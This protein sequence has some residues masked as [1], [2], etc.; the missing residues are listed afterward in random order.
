MKTMQGWHNSQ[1]QLT[2]YLE[3]GDEVEEAFA[4][5]ALNIMPPAFWS[6]RIIQIG[7]PH[8]HVEGIPTFA[9]FYRDAGTWHF[10]GYC[11]RGRIS[12]PSST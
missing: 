9:T 1:Q 3:A 2:P 4:D 11:H 6:T 8:S 7:E 10:G 5:W 12:M